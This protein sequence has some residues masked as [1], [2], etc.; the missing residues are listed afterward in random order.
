MITESMVYWITRLDSI[1]TTFHGITL[2]ILILSLCWLA[3]SIIMFCLMAEYQDDDKEKVM[4]KKN[5]KVS[6]PIFVLAILLFLSS[7]FIPTTKEY[8]AIKLVPMIA[9]N[10]DV[11]ELPAKVVDLAN[12]WIDELK[13]EKK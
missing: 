11:Q 3:I 9:Q 1:Q 5:I 2:G 6:A 8:C 13:P 7:A 10:E 4:A 12:E